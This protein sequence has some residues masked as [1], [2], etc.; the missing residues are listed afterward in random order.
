MVHA[1]IRD[2]ANHTEESDGIKSAGHIQAPAEDELREV[3]IP[4]LPGICDAD[5]GKKGKP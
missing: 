2:T 5:G 1:A 4:D 3:R